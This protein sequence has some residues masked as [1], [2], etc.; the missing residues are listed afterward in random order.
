[1]KKILIILIIVLELSLIKIPKYTELNNLAI[2]EEI[3]IQKNNNYYTIILK[4]IIP[5]RK[6]QGINYEY[7]YYQETSTSITK[8]INKIKQKTKKKLYLQKA[9]SLITNITNSHEIIIELD[10]N[11]STI[12]HTNNIKEKM[13]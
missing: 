9:K 10:I 5:K 6:D 13:N 3:A 4:E 1:M 7:E 2:I 8:A 12:I 11:P